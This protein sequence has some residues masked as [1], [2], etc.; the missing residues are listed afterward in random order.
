MAT[1]I[2]CVEF[3]KALADPT[4]QKILEMLQEKE[5]TVSEVVEAFN[6]TQPTVSHHLEILSRRGLLTSRKEGKRVFY[7]TNK[8]NLVYCCG[9]LMSKFEVD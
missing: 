1:K 6:L 7:R 2:D 4:R 9:N 3:C 8:D 5:K